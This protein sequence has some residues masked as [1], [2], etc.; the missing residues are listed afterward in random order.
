MLTALIVVSSILGYLTIGRVYGKAS[1]DIWQNHPHTSL[2]AKLYFPLSSRKADI[3]G[4]NSHSSLAFPFMIE[5]FGGRDKSKGCAGFCTVYSFT[6]PLFV[7]W[8]IGVHLMRSPV[9]IGWRAL[10]FAFLSL[11]ERLAGAPGMLKD[12]GGRLLSAAKSR[13]KELKPAAAELPTPSEPTL[14]LPEPADPESE[15]VQVVQRRQKLLVEMDRLSVQET[16][17]TRQLGGPDEARKLLDRP[18]KKL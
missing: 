2:Q 5:F 4:K 8:T 10:N 15:Y 18:G 7:G 12:V 14:A 11:P 17:L 13:R 1:W 6:W 9:T 16:N 3:Y